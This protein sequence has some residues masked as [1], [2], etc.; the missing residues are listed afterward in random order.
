M[1]EVNQD[2]AKWLT[3][4]IERKPTRK[5]SALAQ[6]ANYSRSM[7]TKVL[8]G[9]TAASP[10][11]QVRIMLALWQEGVFQHAGEVFAGWA[12]LGLTP[13][14]CLD[15][16]I[17]TSVQ[18][19]HE[20]Q[21]HNTGTPQTPRKSWASFQEWLKQWN[22]QRLDPRLQGVVLESYYTP[23]QRDLAD[24]REVLASAY[25]VRMALW[26]MG[27]IGKTVLAQ[28]V[29]LDSTLETVFSGGVLWTTLG[30]QG[31][32]LPV[33]QQW[34]KYLKV[35]LPTGATESEWVNVIHKHLTAS[36]RAYLCII[37][38]VWDAEQAQPL[39]DATR[40]A[41][42][43][44]TLRERHIA[45]QLATDD[46]IWEVQGLTP[47][48]GLALIQKRCNTAWRPD[49][50]TSAQELY[51]LTE[52][53]PLALVLGAALSKTEGWHQLLTVLRDAKSRLDKLAL[54]RLERREHNLRV[55]LDL[56]YQMLPPTTQVWFRRL[57]ALAPGAAVRFDC[58]EQS[59]GVLEGA[60]ITPDVVKAQIYKALVELV[61]ASLLQ[62]QETGQLYRLHSLV[63][64]Y[65]SKAL[66]ATA[67]A[68]EVHRALLNYQ[69]LTLH[70]CLKPD[71]PLSPSLL[72]KH[73]F[74]MENWVHFLHVWQQ[75]ERGLWKTTSP[76]EAVSPQQQLRNWLWQA[77][78]L[79]GEYLQLQSAWEALIKWNQHL[80]YLCNQCE[81]GADQRRL[82][83][84][85][86]VQE[87]YAHLNLGQM[88]SVAALLESLH[89]LQFDVARHEWLIRAKACEGQWRL[90]QQQAKK[91]REC[92]KWIMRET[93]DM[94]VRYE[95]GT[96]T[97]MA[98][99]E[100][101]EFLGNYEAERGNPYLAEKHWN[102]ACVHQLQLVRQGNSLRLARSLELLK[103]IALWRARHGMWSAALQTG[104]LWALLEAVLTNGLLLSAWVS[105]LEWALRSK[106]TAFGAWAFAILRE[107]IA[108]S[109]EGEDHTIAYLWLAT[110]CARQQDWEEAQH[111]VA[112]AQQRVQEY[113]DHVD[114]CPWLE[115]VVQAISAKQL[116]ALPP[117]NCL[118]AY[119]TEHENWSLQDGL[120]TERVES[121]LGVDIEF[122]TAQMPN[123]VELISLEQ[124]SDAQTELEAHSGETGCR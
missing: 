110:W 80:R 99:L 98:Y 27:G 47:A 103:R 93:D 86:L 15:L 34:G 58:I 38:D 18:D 7:L 122:S 48:E 30:L 35:S 104:R 37:D 119:N 73:A 2:F 64:L 6:S 90:Q 11:F 66:D 63:A 114:L 8:K 22:D 4:K 10:E 76:I 113:S 20:L 79:G 88:D 5:K 85:L 14:D 117:V 70:M 45:Q 74:L 44:L 31:S 72:A 100:V 115:D 21:L 82:I 77:H 40:D 118:R 81:P 61:D 26:G 16:V 32:A 105:I 3:E 62:E 116:P 24:I 106:D 25:P 56:S 89:Q 60:S 29:A 33:L 65:A 28:A 59:W 87:I 109:A 83:G 42:V 36:N 97:W 1:P 12:L 68:P 17:Q 107:G 55:T 75:V 124:E 92:R 50:T 19:K 13:Q 108:H 101:K 102:E 51:E 52:G 39:L 43:L 78:E 23:R 94:L 95:D 71:L 112:L 96:L 111:W 67:E 84:M 120:L 57:G 123:I 41:S 121:L 69:L 54:P 49:W 91:A 53:L 9:D 46:Y